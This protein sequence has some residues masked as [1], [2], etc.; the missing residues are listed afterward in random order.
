LIQLLILLQIGNRVI[1]AGIEGVAAGNPFNSQPATTPDPVASDGFIT[2]LGTRRL[3]TAGRRERARE[4]QLI[5]AN[6]T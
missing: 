6:D 3:K 5:E 2:V 4:S 1:P